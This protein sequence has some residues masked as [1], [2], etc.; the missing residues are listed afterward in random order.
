MDAGVA[1]VKI[2]D[3]K[4]YEKSLDYKVRKHIKDIGLCAVDE[5]SY[6]D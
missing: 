3:W 1:R 6:E 2:T 4:E 5:I